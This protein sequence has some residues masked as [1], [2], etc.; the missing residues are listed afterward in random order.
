LE[1]A[2]AYLSYVH[3]SYLNRA[4][5]P[6]VIDKWKTSTYSGKGVFQGQN[7]YDYMENHMGYRYVL[8]DCEVLSGQGD[9]EDTIRL[10]LVLENVGFSN[11]YR[12]FATS[13]EVVAP[14]GKVTSFP[15]DTDLRFLSGGENQLLE[16]VI[17]IKEI[18]VGEFRLSLKIQDET[19]QALIKLANYNS[20][21]QNGLFFG[22]LKIE[23]SPSN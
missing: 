22:T 14:S 19:T 3:I 9:D 21:D 4:W 16:L 10:A 23:S 15:I 2:I 1:P 13:I 5:D 18:G 20:F 12:P 17:P 6:T 8:R 7:G 11:C